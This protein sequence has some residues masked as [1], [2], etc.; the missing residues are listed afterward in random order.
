MSGEGWMVVRVVRGRVRG[1]L[2]DGEGRMVR[3]CPQRVQ[4]CSN[5]NNMV[6]RGMAWHH[7]NVKRV[8]RGWHHERAVRGVAGGCREDAER[9]V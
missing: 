8:V 7:E 2:G 6:W 4:H 3:R 1:W 5:S 9:V